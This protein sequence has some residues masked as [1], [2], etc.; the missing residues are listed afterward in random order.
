[1]RIGTNTSGDAAR[2]ASDPKHDGQ[3]AD[4]TRNGRN[5]W[6]RSGITNDNTNECWNRRNNAMARNTSLHYT[7][8]IKRTLK[9]EKQKIARVYVVV[10]VTIR[11]SSEKAFRKAMRE[12][13]P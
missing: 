6:K 4:S 1:M 10:P 7:N 11:A 12:A 8:S 13:N 9:P 5:I 2:Y 3:T